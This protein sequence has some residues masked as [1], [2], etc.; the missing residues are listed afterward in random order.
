M[1]I[2]TGFVSNSSSSSFVV[3]GKKITV[4]RMIK[5]MEEKENVY[6]YVKDGHCY[7]GCDFFPVKKGMV[8]FLCLHSC[9][10]EYYIVQH[11][12]EDKKSINV[13]NLVFDNKGNIDVMIFEIDMH[14]CK[15]LDDLKERYEEPYGD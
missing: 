2:R 5:A 8:K 12:I 10:F 6:A 11:M 4:D 9:Q 15:T 14:V 13:N 7:D 3:I 1:K